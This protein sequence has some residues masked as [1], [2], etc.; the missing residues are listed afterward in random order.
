MQI[1]KVKRMGLEIWTEQEPAW[2]TEL[3]LN[4]KKPIFVAHTPFLSYPPSGMTWVNHSEV[5]LTPDEFPSIARS[6]LET[7]AKNYRVSKEAISTLKI[8]PANYGKLIGFETNFTGLLDKKQVDVK[9]FTGRTKGKGPVTMQVYAPKGK[10]QHM[11]EQ[12]RRSWEHTQ[13]LEE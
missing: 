13:Y 2:N 1:H 7:A 4:G 5:E 6:T 10:L 8:T 9:V 11:K 3:M 12:I